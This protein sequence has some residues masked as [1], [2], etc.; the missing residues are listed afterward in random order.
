MET[1]HT[2]SKTSLWSGRIISWLCILFLLVD[3][4]MKIVRESHSVDGTLKLG[5]TD[6]LVQPLGI[7]L[8]IFTVAYIFPR[9][10]IFGAILLTAYLGGATSIMIR[11]H[12]AFSFPAI[13]CIAVWLGLFFA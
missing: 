11:E 4:I 6:N 12:Q 13:F 10:A 2:Q 8:L 5:F 9:T 7:L 3:A 1:P